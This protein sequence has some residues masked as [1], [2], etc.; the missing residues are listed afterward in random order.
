MRNF[1]SC[2]WQHSVGLRLSDGQK[3][4]ECMV[5]T[6]KPA[7]MLRFLQEIAFQNSPITRPAVKTDQKPSSWTKKW[8]RSSGLQLNFSPTKILTESLRPLQLSFIEAS[9][10]TDNGATRNEASKDRASAQ[11]SCHFFGA[12]STGGKCS[13]PCWAKAGL[14]LNS[15]RSDVSISTVEGPNG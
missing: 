8:S 10:N 4:Q 13:G 2:A 3:W 1:R 14:D 6:Q 12:C 11:K 7:Q 15:S 9:L 5:T